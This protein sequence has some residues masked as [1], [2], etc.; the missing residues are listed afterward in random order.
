[1][2][3]L[4]LVKSNAEVARMVP[5]DCGLCDIRPKTRL[6]STI[7]QSRPQALALA[8]RQLLPL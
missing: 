1:M 4:R 8:G 3:V 5:G 2:G 7:P 6:A